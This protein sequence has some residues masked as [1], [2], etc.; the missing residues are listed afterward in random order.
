M[1]MLALL[2]FEIVVL[3]A[4]TSNWSSSCCSTVLLARLQ[5]SE[6]PKLNFLQVCIFTIWNCCVNARTSNWSSSCCST[7]LLATLQTSEGPKLLIFYRFAFLPFEIVVLNARTSNWSSS[8]CSTVLLA[9]LQTSEGPKLNFL[10]GLH[11]NH[12]KLLCWMLGRQTDLPATTLDKQ[13][14]AVSTQQHHHH[15][16]RV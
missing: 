15:H 6:G 16:C 14:M 4:R 5:T 7:V 13:I 2:P 12:L 3:N 9:T 8:C 1:S 10:A 11:C